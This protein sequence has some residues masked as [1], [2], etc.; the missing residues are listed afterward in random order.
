MR[1]PGMH[2]IIASNRGPRSS[3]KFSGVSPALPWIPLAYIAWKSHCRD[4][5]AYF[6]LMRLVGAAIW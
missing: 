6:S 3:P 2:L 5:E 4:R 1:G